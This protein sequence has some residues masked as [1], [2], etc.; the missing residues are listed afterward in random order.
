MPSENSPA[1]SD[2]NTYESEQA[3]ILQ[4]KPKGVVLSIKPMVEEDA[5]AFVIAC[6]SLGVHGE[7]AEH[8][9]AELRRFK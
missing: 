9:A 2:S 8:F 7:V 1:S 5:L 3:R 4:T 6:N